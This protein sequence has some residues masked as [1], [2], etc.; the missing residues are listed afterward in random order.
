MV[1]LGAEL[2]RRGRDPGT[3]RRALPPAQ[4]LALSLRSRFSFTSGQSLSTMA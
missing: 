4:L 2:R 3:L 1:E